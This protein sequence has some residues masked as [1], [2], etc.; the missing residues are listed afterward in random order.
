[1]REGAVVGE[2]GKSSWIAVQGGER[3]RVRHVPGRTR[4]DEQNRHTVVVA[5]NGG[6]ARRIGLK[7]EIHL[8]VVAGGV[9]SGRGRHI[10][11][12]LADIAAEV[13]GG[14]G[15]VDIVG[16]RPG[17]SDHQTA[18]AA[19]GCREGNTCEK[20]KTESR[21]KVTHETPVKAQCY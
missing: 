21:S 18:G 6:M 1:M 13:P 20:E 2:V 10:R 9:R 8:V 3:K 11:Q 12:R 16:A 15:N 4:H 7:I 19:K 17:N 14:V 5:A